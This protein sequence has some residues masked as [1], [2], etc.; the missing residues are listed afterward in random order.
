LV[1]T[2]FHENANKIREEIHKI[3]KGQIETFLDVVKKAIDEK[4]VK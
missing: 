4:D 2:T 3:P 1:K